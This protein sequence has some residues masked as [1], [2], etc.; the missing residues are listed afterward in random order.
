MY[1]VMFQANV[2]IHRFRYCGSI[3]VSKQPK[4][5]WTQNIQ[6][7]ERNLEIE[8]FRREVACACVCCLHVWFFVFVC[9]CVCVRVC[10]CVFC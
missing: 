1:D 6:G 4:V 9:V 7:L 2:L 5:E 8:V 10:V 3:L